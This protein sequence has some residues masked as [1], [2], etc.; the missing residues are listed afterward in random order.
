MA[1][2]SS[3]FASGTAARCGRRPLYFWML[4]IG[5]DRGTGVGAEGVGMGERLNEGFVPVV[6][7]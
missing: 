1:L 3:L 2:V 7:G 4:V 5:I 6:S